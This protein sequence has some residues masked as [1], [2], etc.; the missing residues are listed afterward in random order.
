MS[1]SGPYRLASSVAVLL[2]SPKLGA[3]KG[4]FLL[5]S[6]GT[7]SLC[8]VSPPSE[9]RENRGQTERFPV[10]TG[11]SF[12]DAFWPCHLRFEAGRG[13]KAGRKPENV[14]SVPGFYPPSENRVLPDPYQLPPDRPD[15][16]PDRQIHQRDHE[17]QPPPF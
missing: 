5:C 16:Q 6:K 13:G 4:T 9:N 14:P 2:A 17:A 3:V 11:F 1:P 8:R 12:G 10:F 7:L 15:P